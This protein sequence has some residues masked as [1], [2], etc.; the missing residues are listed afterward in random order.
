MT[1][2]YRRKK[3]PNCKISEWGRW[4]EADPFVVISVRSRI[5]PTSYFKCQ[6]SVGDFLVFLLTLLL[7]PRSP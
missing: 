5:I 2:W 7:A 3:K 1:H 6:Q 4:D